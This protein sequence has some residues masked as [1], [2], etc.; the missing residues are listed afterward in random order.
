MSLFGLG[1]VFPENG[2]EIETIIGK[3][4]QKSRRV[5]EVALNTDGF[6]FS[7]RHTTVQV[8][9]H[10]VGTLEQVPNAD[11]DDEEI[12]SHDHE[13]IGISRQLW[14]QSKHDGQHAQH[15]KREDDG[16]LAAA[17]FEGF[18]VVGIHSGDALSSTLVVLVNQTELVAA[19][20][21]HSPN[22]KGAERKHGR[23]PVLDIEKVEGKSKGEDTGVYA[24]KLP[25]F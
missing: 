23:T 20:P 21:S 13:V 24:T 9:V 7:V 17:V 6:D 10:L 14:R 12:R 5:S 25:F 15:R 8:A 18:K 11:H 1:S 22:P 3:V 19:L 16:E 4:V 2:T